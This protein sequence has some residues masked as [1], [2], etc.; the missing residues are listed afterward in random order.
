MT[1]EEVE[2]TICDKMEFRENVDAYFKNNKVLWKCEECGL[3]FRWAI[4]DIEAKDPADQFKIPKTQDDWDEAVII[5]SDDDVCW[6]VPDEGDDICDGCQKKLKQIE[7]KG[8]IK[9]GVFK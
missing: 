4:F 7:M 9:T 5:A 3:N 1:K 8:L 6:F 2:D